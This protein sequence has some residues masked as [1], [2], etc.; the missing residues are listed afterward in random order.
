[1][2]TKHPIHPTRPIHPRGRRTRLTALAALPLLLGGALSACGSDD[3][4]NPGG[5]AADGTPTSTVS[6]DAAAHND[7]DVAFA[8]QMI[9]HHQQALAMVEMTRG[10]PLTAPV[11]TLVQGIHDAQAPEIETMTGWLA[12]WGEPTPSAD[13]GDQRGTGGMGDMG[14]M[15]EMGGMGGGSMP[16][17]MS[18]AQMSRLEAAPDARFQRM[19][20]TMMI[21]HHEGAVQ[22]ARTEIA[23]GQY[24]PAIALARSIVK[25]QSAE[26]ARMRALLRG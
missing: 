17:M 12:A 20:L 9:P 16:G 26:I 19:W 4:D 8:T 2:T 5:S 22:M 21:A 10:R 3:S 11:R 13:P 14:D 24:P 15:G 1:M 6:V 25:G 23:Q 7:A 18:G